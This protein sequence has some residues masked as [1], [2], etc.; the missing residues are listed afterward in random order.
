MSVQGIP[1]PPPLRFKTSLEQFGAKVRESVEECTSSALAGEGR[2]ATAEGSGTEQ[3]FQ[4]CEGQWSQAMR[5]ALETSA[6]A[7][8]QVG[9]FAFTITITC[10]SPSWPPPLPQ[11][12]E[13]CDARAC[14]LSWVDQD[15][16][17]AFSKYR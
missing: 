8:K 14:G 5:D 17:T 13:G 15:S 2:G 10:G 6:V 7:D 4:L 12:G 3:T 1:L 11:A 9:S 16:C